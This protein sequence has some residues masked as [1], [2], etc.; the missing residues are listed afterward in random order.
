MPASDVPAQIHPAPPLSTGSPSPADN[1]LLD[2]AV[3]PTELVRY[4]VAGQQLPGAFLLGTWANLASRSMVGG[5]VRM[6]ASFRFDLDT[7]V[8]Q[9]EQNAFNPYLQPTNYSLFAAYVEASL[10][11]GF[12]LRVGRQFHADVADYLAFD[13]GNL[14]WSIPKT[15]FSVELY[16]GLRSAFAIATG[17]LGSSLY[18]LDG[19]QQ[20]TSAQPVAGAVLRW[21]SG[22]SGALAIA[23]P[24]RAEAEVGFRWSWRTDAQL[25]DPTLPSWP[26][27][28]AQEL[29]ASAGGDLGPVHLFGAGAYELV[30]QTIMNAQATAS[31]G[32][33]R[34]FGWI[35]KSA[36]AGDTLS[37]GYQRYRPVFALDSIFN[38]FSINPYDEYA[39]TLG[40]WA[41]GRLRLDLRGFTRWYTSATTDRTGNV[42]S[43]APGPQSANGG[44]LSSVFAHGPWQLDAF[45]D[46]ETGAIGT[47]LVVDGGTRVRLGD[48]FELFARVSGARFDIAQTPTQTGTSFGFAVGGT[49]H[50]PA[51]ANLSL[52]V[53]ETLN[54]FTPSTPSVF[55]VADLARWL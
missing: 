28:T 36:F 21:R 43:F 40:V 10:P 49:W 42:L 38:Y 25:V 2:L 20:E 45:C 14:D 12:E 44:R 13:G 50:L 47:R 17:Q 35:S 41:F 29:I 7:A 19:V 3:V 53:Q 24:H 37:L 8:T 18:Q 55:A 9:K 1:V 26:E 23:V 22:S 46:G 11:A 32:L 15:P 30:L 52:I 31:I 51:N 48:A 34:L 16:G 27:T 54:P 5:N 4:D 6:V 39:A 33:D